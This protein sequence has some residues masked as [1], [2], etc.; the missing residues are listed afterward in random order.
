MPWACEGYSDEHKLGLPKNSLSVRGGTQRRAGSVLGGWPK[1][2]VSE[3]T[4]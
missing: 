1:G 3:S 2:H 4:V